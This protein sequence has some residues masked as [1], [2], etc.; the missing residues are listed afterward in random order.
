MLEKEIEGINKES[1]IKGILRL[2]RMKHKANNP[3]SLGKLIQKF[4]FPALATLA[5]GGIAKETIIDPMITKYQ[6]MKS[7]GMLKEKT[8]QLKGVSDTQLKDY[9]NVVKTFSPKAASDPLV[10]GALVNKMVQ[11]GGI[12]HK[13]VQD[14]ANIQSGMSPRAGVTE[15][16]IA[17]AAKAL[18]SIGGSGI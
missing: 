11:F 10:A 9:F 13:L 17:A 15:T 4:T 18:G 1:S 8:P 12:D 16:A 6:T 3:D 5:V 7:F 2:G 14:I